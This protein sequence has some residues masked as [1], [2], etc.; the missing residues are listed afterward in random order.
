[1]AKQKK[2][3][4]SFNPKTQ[5]KRNSA[6]TVAALER[7]SEAFRVLLWRMGK[8]HKLSPIAVQ[9][10]T[11]LQYH[12]E[13][14]CTVGVMAQEFNMTK[15]T[16]SEA[17]FTLESK[18]LVIKAASPFDARSIVLHLTEAG[19]TLGEE[20]GNF[21]E[22]LETVLATLEA[23]QHAALLEGALTL[24]RGLHEAGIVRTERMCFTCKHYAERHEGNPH[25][26]LLLRQ[27]LHHGIPEGKSM[28]VRIDCE[29]HEAL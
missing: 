18:G 4:S 3:A 29:E 28:P 6:R 8:E 23:P 16:V 19:K 2:T 24:I 20:L 14:L 22:P 26:C 7:I 25:Y 12:A 13:E 10:L 1:M 15:Q 5:V 27:A 11:F 21:S 17:V 9:I